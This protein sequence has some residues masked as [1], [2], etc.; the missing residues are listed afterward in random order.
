LAA[1]LWPTIEY[2]LDGKVARGRLKAATADG[3]RFWLHSFAEFV[4]EDTPLREIDAEHFERWLAQLRTRRGLELKPSSRN[5]VSTPIRAFFTW[6]H[7]RGLIECDPCVDVERA[8]VPEAPVRALTREQVAKV[9]AAA[10]NHEWRAM[11]L[12]AVNLAL[13]IG[14]LATMRVEH[15]D[16]DRQ[17][18]R[19]PASKGGDTDELATDGEAGEVLAHWV[20]HGLD[21]AVAGPMWPSPDRPGE[22]YSRSWIGANLARIGRSVGVDMSAHDLRH[23]TATDMDREGVP[24][25]IGMKVMRHKSMGS[26]QRYSVASLNETRK[27]LS[28]RVPF[29]ETRNGRPPEGD[30]PFH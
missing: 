9:V 13:R 18:L 8:R 11:I 5:T 23:T 29:H 6:C 14:D 25:P 21:G 30:R 10:P 7:R 1:E 4:G 19:I 15:W 24:V 22:N 2:W 27:V 20:D 12:V 26:Y 28:Q 17:V 16:R 3:Q